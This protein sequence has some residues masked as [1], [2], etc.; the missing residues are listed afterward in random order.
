M[1]STLMVLPAIAIAPLSIYAATVPSLLAST[2]SVHLTSPSS[3]VASAPTLDLT[4]STALLAATHSSLS[5]LLSYYVPNNL[6]VYDQTETPWHESG[7][8][9][10]GFMDF[11][12][13][14]GDGS[15]VGTVGEALG[16]ASFGS[17]Q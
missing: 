10:G 5:A 16:N 11:T 3:L 14:S 1:L 4:S 13:W 8:I 7:M 17:T 9:W 2:P 12:K 15:F 6:G